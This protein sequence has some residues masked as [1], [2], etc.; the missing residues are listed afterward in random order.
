MHKEFEML[1]T[2][3]SIF[4][5]KNLLK[6]FTLKKVK[7][8]SLN[9][10]CKPIELMTFPAGGKPVYLK[11][12]RRRWVVKGKKES[13]TNTYDLN[14]QGVKAT[15]EFADFLKGLDREALDEFLN[16]WPVYR[17]MWEKNTSLVQRFLKWIQWQRGTGKTSRA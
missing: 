14:Y 17:R 7:E 8:V 3:A 12:K 11:I 16:A 5:P 1:D 10:Y 6:F 9:G 15:K 4:M 2:L 13:Y